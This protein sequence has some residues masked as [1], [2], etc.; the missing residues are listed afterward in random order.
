MRKNEGVEERVGR[1]GGGLAPR[2]AGG[3]AVGFTK[4]KDDLSPLKRKEERN[5]CR[6]R[7]KHTTGGKGGKKTI[8]D[9]QEKKKKHLSKE[10]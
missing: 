10:V 3:R 7:G 9:V 8:F 4:K 1:G 5:A 6:K 2:F